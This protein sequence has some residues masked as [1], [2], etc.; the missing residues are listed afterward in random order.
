MKS[1]VQAFALLAYALALAF[2]LGSA[3]A[4]TP[5]PKKFDGVL[6]NVGDGRQ[7]AYLIPPFA[8][9][10]A[11]FVEKDSKE[12]LTMAWF[13]GSKEGES[14]V[15]IVVSTYDGVNKRWGNASVVSQR[16]GYSNQNPVLFWDDANA[17]LHLFHSQ[18]QADKGES[19]STVWHLEASGSGWSTP[20]KIFSKAG[21]FD[22]NR[23]VVGLDH[24]WI[25]PM[26]YASQP[27]YCHIKTLQPGQD[28]EKASWGNEN[29]VNTDDLVQP[30]VIRPAKG[31]PALKAFMRDRNSEHIYTA[32]STDDGMTWSAAKAS[33][34]PN[35]NAGIQALTL[36]SGRVALVY[37]PQTTSR[38]P[39]A[40]SLS[41]DGGESW[42][43]TRILE[44]EDGKQEFSYP[45]LLQT[46]DGRIHVTYTWKRETIKYSV[47]DEDWVMAQ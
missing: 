41:E 6:R 18:Q 28:P 15:A 20:K 13:S 37:N 35:N 26:Y 21:S 38:D 46:S 2:A 36:A 39:I 1:R 23:M 27:N 32:E 7:D 14:G 40:I 42:A 24:R 22:R 3:V 31:K 4:S 19:E 33:S 25:F 29:F 11:S 8:S 12:R 43:Y 47:I 17:T 10:H 16:D 30:T 45:S 34:L 9:N 5:S 44:H